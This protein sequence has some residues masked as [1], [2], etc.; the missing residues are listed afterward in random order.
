MVYVVGKWQEWKERQEKDKDKGEDKNKGRVLVLSV[1]G[2]PPE[3]QGRAAKEGIR[4]E[5]LA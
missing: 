3:H 2:N 4:S 1:S 5:S